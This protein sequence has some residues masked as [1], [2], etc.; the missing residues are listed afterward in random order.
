M[1]ELCGEFGRVLRTRIGSPFVIAGMQ[2]AARQPC[3]A[4]GFEANGGFLLGFD[5]ETAGGILPRLM[6]RDSLLPLLATLAMARQRGISLGGLV[7]SLPARRTATDRLE[8]IATDTSAALISGLAASPTARAGFFAGFGAEALVDH[9]DGLRVTFADGL[10]LH[11]RPSGNAPELRCYAEA[12]TALRAET[13]LKKA[14]SLV[15]E[16]LA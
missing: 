6:T 2:D 12:E 1:V 13:A 16:R 14:L 9:T 11:L 8:N 5:A 4:V 7:A 15:R 10:I 3:H